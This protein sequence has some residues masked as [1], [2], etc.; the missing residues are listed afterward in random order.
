MKEGKSNNKVAFSHKTNFYGMTL[1]VG[2]QDPLL[3]REQFAVSLRKQR[4]ETMIKDRRKKLLLRVNASHFTSSHI[5][6]RIQ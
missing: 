6:S 4:K 5:G 3:K 2:T 1:V